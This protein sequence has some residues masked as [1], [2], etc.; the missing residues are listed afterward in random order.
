MKNSVQVESH[1]IACGF[2]LL[3][4]PLI[5]GWSDGVMLLLMPD[6][7][8]FYEQPEDK[9]GGF[10]RFIARVLPYRNLLIQAS[11]I[12]I[13]RLSTNCAGNERLRFSLNP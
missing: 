7:S 5:E 1:T 13:T 9:I 11:A 6:D 8:R 10:G 12:A 3:R 4:V 2:P